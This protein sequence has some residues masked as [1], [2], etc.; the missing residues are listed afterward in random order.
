MMRGTSLTK[1]ISFN[2]I[3]KIESLLAKKCFTFLGKIVRIPCKNIPL[4]YCQLAVE[5]RD[6]WV[7]LTPQ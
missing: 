5:K 4:D 6:I 1:K 7:D 2:S 3:R